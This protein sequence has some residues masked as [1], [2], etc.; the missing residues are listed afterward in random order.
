[1]T[2]N[3]F[4]VIFYVLFWVVRIKG[5]VRRGRQPLLRGPEWFFNV[6]VQ[7][8][9]YAGAG[10][11][12]LHRY[13]M[14]MFI[15]FAVDIPVATGLADCGALCLDPHQSWLLRGFGRAAGPALGDS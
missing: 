2:P 9:F 4:I 10:R 14:R 5:C 8:D 15:P 3:Q 7:P 11:K 1:M 13:W 6:P 12:I